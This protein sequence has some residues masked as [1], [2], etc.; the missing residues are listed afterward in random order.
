[1]PIFK[2]G[3]VYRHAML[4]EGLHDDNSYQGGGLAI[5]RQSY[6]ESYAKQ[7]L[8]GAGFMLVNYMVDGL[9]EHVEERIFGEAVPIDINKTGGTIPSDIGTIDDLRKLLEDLKQTSKEFGEKSY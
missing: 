2:D 5:F 9:G 3:T 1:M 4:L 6:G 8:F 7:G